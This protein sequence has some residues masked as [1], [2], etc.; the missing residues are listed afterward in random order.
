MLMKLLL[1]GSMFGVSQRWANA[2]TTE[3]AGNAA[4]VY[5]QAA[6]ILRDD[7]AKNIM[8]PSSSNATF[9]RY[10]PPLPDDWVA[11]EKQDYDLHANVRELV[12]QA[13]TMEQA[14]WPAALPNGKNQNRFP[15][16]NECRNLANELGDA[17]KYQSLVL[18][19]QPSAFAKSEDLLRLTDMLKNQPPE[20]LVRL[21]VAMGIDALN[22]SKLTVMVANV[23]ITEDARNHHD[24]PL[25]TATQWIARL[26][27]HPDA[28]TERDQ[29]LKGEG[30]GA[31]N[32]P[33]FTAT[34]DRILETVHRCQTERD[35]VAMSL[36]AHVYQYKHGTWPANLDELKTELPRVPIDPWGDGKQTLGYALIKGGLPD[37][38][39]RPL[40]YS[41]CGMKD[42]L[43]FRTDEPE[44]SFY[45]S[46]GL[47]RTPGQRKQGGQFRDVAGWA[48]AEGKTN[49]PTTRPLE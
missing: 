1:I 7:D 37:D 38:S 24:L 41:R 13:G 35:F 5:L 49:G 23:E 28:Q 10:Y 25:A 8:S 4:D 15:Y 30:P 45:N 3:P 14:N 42:G 9:T 21:L 31:L 18:S 32:N 16:L 20:S 2:Q 12:H 22:S 34:R 27:D 46:D 11:M 43:F 29:A 47:N 39:D 26:L 36:A 40:V 44:Y 6:K 33:V 17:A 19:E 48:P